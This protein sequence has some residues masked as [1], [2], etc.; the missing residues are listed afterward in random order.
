[1]FGSTLF[2]KDIQTKILDIKVHNVEMWFYSK[3][4]LVLEG[5]PF[6]I[7]FNKR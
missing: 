3:I 7:L 2:W 5:I 6:F 4:V 1:M